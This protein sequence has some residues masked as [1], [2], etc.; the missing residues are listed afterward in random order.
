M[1]YITL[2]YETQATCTINK[3]INDSF[4]RCK[5]T[6]LVKGETTKT[7]HVIDIHPHHITRYALFPECFCNLQIL[8][9]NK[10]KTKHALE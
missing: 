1:Q 10:S 3:L 9:V 4:P 7:I 6:C 2:I 8:I 5:K